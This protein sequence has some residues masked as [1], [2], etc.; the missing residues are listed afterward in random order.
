MLTGEDLYCARYFSQISDFQRWHYLVRQNAYYMYERRVAV[1]APG[2]AEED[3]R[4]AQILVASRL[5][6]W[7][8]PGFLAS[9][10]LPHVLAAIAK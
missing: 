2:T 10:K 9:L 6:G 1:G 5:G 3:W 4:A 8:L 7:F